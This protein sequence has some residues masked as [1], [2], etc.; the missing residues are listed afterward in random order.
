MLKV[1]SLTW[2]IYERPPPLVRPLIS[3]ERRSL[4]SEMGR[5]RSVVVKSETGLGLFSA[6]YLNVLAVH[7]RCIN[8]LIPKQHTST[9]KVPYRVWP[10]SQLVSYSAP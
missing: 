7:K 8:Y 4:R 10:V 1:V 6:I 3:L 2:L 5:S 9:Q